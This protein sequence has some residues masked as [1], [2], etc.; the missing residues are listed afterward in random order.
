[1]AVESIAKT[2]GTGSGID[3]TALVSQLVDAQFQAKTA[4]LEKKSEALTA[5][6]SSASQLK[7]SIS[8]FST[9]LTA[10]A[11]S[12]S[13]STQPTSSNAS[14]VTV[15]AQPGAQIGTLDARLEVRRLAAA[16]VASTAPIA[17]ATA[18]VGMGTL[19]L[20]F[21]TATVADGAMSAF[22][23]GATSIDIAI[24]EA[25]SSLEGIMKAINAANAGVTASI[26]TDPDGARLVLKG[27][28]GAAK[29]F[30][31]SATE[32]PGAEGL[33][34]LAIGVGASGTTIGSAAADAEIAVDGI[35]VKRS[36][37]GLSD[38][39]P[40]VRID[41]VSAQPGT[42]VRIGSTSPTEALRQAVADVVD[43]YNELLSIVQAEVDPVAGS[44]R[45]DMAARTLAQS[46]ARLTLAPLVPGAGTDAP[47]TL[48]A[49][50]VAT[51]RDGTLRIDADRLGAALT[52]HPEAVEAMFRAESGLP[53]ALAAISTAAASTATG[54]GASEARYT[55]AAGNLEEDRSEALAAAEAL[56]ARMTQQFARM[57]SKV[58]AYK[59]TQSFL[60]QQIDAWNA[61]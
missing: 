58:A 16:Q 6:I 40:G 56:R 45:S 24:G 31:L 15:A 46:L 44:L 52:T 38:L 17:D 7:S 25:D 11:K 27:T 20:T 2:L 39:I 61:D 59:S 57:D 60:Q 54:L 9:A 4:T 47:T 51:N 26:L 5:Q 12:G 13:L 8:G 3:I 34:A 10:L 1:M 23:P 32:T 49:L 33:S 28:T 50:G 42:I 53:A 48:A 22:D 35:A 55:E 41:L 30:T 43:T 14:L 36:G 29:A 37:N 21:G 18:A 19:T